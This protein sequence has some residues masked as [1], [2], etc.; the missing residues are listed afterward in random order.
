[1]NVVIREFKPEDYYEVYKLWKLTKQVALD[2]KWIY[3][4]KAK[5]QPDL[6]LV[7]EVDGK[8]VGAVVSTYD[9]Q[10]S[11]VHH[12]AVHPDYQNRGIGS[13][14]LSE[15]ERRLKARGCL[16]LLITVNKRNPRYEE[17]LKFYRKRGFRV[18]GDYT[19]VGKMI[20]RK[21]DMVKAYGVKEKC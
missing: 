1:M 16:G 14:L 3:E 11:H 15:I 13:L 9:V 7:A 19:H 6:F 21:E 20:G 10:F 18:I 5:R 2:R 12:L 17:V 8:V 4:L